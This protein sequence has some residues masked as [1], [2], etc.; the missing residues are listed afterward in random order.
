MNQEFSFRYDSYGYGSATISIKIDSKEIQFHA[1]Y[2]GSNPLCD[3]LEGLS[4]IIDK[5]YDHC[6][7]N[8]LSEPGNLIFDIKVDRF[9]YAHIL[10]KEKITIGTLIPLCD[11]IQIIVKEASRNL[12]L[13]GLVGF[14]KDW[15]A[16]EDVFP[17]SAYLR[18]KGVDFSIGDND[19]AISSISKEVKKLGDI[20]PENKEVLL[21]A[22]TTS[23]GPF[24]DGFCEIGRSDGFDVDGQF[25]DTNFPGFKEWYLK[26]DQFDPYSDV[27]VFNPDGYE[28][29][30]NQ[31]YEYAVMVRKIVPRGINVY[32]GFWKEF[33]DNEW[34]FCKTYIP[35][36]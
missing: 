15:C 33:G 21:H 16:H 35:F 25:F 19:I 23:S 3:L 28:S 8:W 31:G 7:F 6:R 22:E 34:L 27:G 18:L 20:I 12:V 1:S 13:H 36:I 5:E 30:V 26:A 11:F 32:Y 10:V 24:W 14:S 2:I 4:G 29:W 17:V 9:N